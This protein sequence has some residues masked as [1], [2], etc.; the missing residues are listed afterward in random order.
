VSR[1]NDRMRRYLAPELLSPQRY[2]DA[3]MP[4]LNPHDHELTRQSIELMVECLQG[5]P[6][7][8]LAAGGTLGPKLGGP[9]QVAAMFRP[10][11]NDPQVAAGFRARHE[12]GMRAEVLNSALHALATWDKPANPDGSVDQIDFD[13]RFVALSNVGRFVHERSDGRCVPLAHRV[14]DHAEVLRDLMA[15]HLLEPLIHRGPG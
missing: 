4:A 1:D 14:R 15:A 8:R 10:A 13:V 2:A 5:G 3:A 11:S 6:A 7:R 12:Q 9:E